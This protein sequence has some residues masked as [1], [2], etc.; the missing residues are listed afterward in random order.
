MSSPV[1][2][3]GATGNVGRPLVTALRT[4][5]VPVRPASRR[6]T[7]P[8][9]IAFDF[10]VPETWPSAFDGVATMFLVRPPHLA[11]IARDMVPSLEEARRRGVR[12][13]VLLSV[14]GADRVPILPHARL[15]RWLRASGMAWTFLR[16]SYFDQNLSTVF[17]ADIRDHD[18]ILVP[19]GAGRTAFVDALD[20]ASVAATVLRDPGLHRGR[21]WSPTG[22]EALTYAEVART[23]SEVLGRTVTYRDPGIVGYFRHAR[24]DLGMDTA[25][26]LTTTV[27]HATARL[28]VAKHLTDDVRRVTGQDPLSFRSFVDRERTVWERPGGERPGGERP[29]A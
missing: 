1:L 7:E 19:A 29:G 18:R 27:I 6:G 14:Q 10:G 2:V 4:M 16:P 23:L 21:S 5:G 20:V 28:G 25:R 11:N 17:A 13:V 15:E 24:A 22:R 26:A 8:G 12:H 3:T 9:G